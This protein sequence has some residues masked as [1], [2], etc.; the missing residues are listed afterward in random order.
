MERPRILVSAP[1]PPDV[2]DGLDQFLSDN[3]LHPIPNPEGRA[4]LGQEEL[5]NAIKEAEGLIIGPGT[6]DRTCLSAAKRLR[7]I[8]KHGVGVENIDLDTAAELGIPVANLPGVNADSVA[9][10]ALG[11]ILTLTRGLHIV[12]SRSIGGIG[13]RWVGR[14]LKEMT[15]GVVGLGFVGRAVALRASAF[16]MHVAARYP[17]GSE[18]FAKEQGIELLAFGDLLRRSDVLVI[19]IPEN[20]ETRGLIGQEELAFLGGDSFLVNVSRGGIVDESALLQAVR[21]GT[22]SGAGLDVVVDEPA[23]GD[24]PLTR[25][26]NIVVTPHIA[27]ATREAFRRTAMNAAENLVTMLRGGAPASLLNGVTLDTPLIR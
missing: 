5:E 26:P 22:I 10:L 14:E 21:S 6:L 12:S 25:E 4:V 8:S 17:T 7:A 1:T 2:R 13:E 18:D 9:D 15:L 23:T 3:G 16:G 19:A 27:G 11:L 20:D 24:N